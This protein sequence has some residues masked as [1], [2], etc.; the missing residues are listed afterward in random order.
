MRAA[1]GDS[2]DGKTVLENI[3]SQINSFKK[4]PDKK[5][6]FVSE[7]G[8]FREGMPTSFHTEGLVFRILKKPKKEWVFDHSATHRRSK[9]RR[10]HGDIPGQ[11]FIYCKI[12]SK[13]PSTALKRAC[14][15]LIETTS[16]YNY[17][18]NARTVSSET[19]GDPRNHSINTIYAGPIHN[20]F[21]DG[22]VPC[23]EYSWD[24]DYRGSLSVRKFKPKL[25]DWSFI[26]EERLDILR[27][28]RRLKYGGLVRNSIIDLSES[29]AL[30]DNRDILIRLWAILE[31][32]ALQ[33]RADYDILSRRVSR[34]F[35]Q[36]REMR[37][38][39]DL[40]R[41]YRNKAVH[42][43]EEVDGPEWSVW[44]AKYFVEK[45]ILF[46]LSTGFLI[47]DR[48]AVG[49]FLDM[50]DNQSVLNTRLRI[51]KAINRFDGR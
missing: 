21:E 4:M 17:L 18:I 20:I 19:A 23:H 46:H 44:K 3:R 38:I 40:L 7:I 25:E 26:R 1:S 15:H 41:K 34:I 31:R 43:L 37:E 6:I 32:L 27:R 12:T 50:P 33:S 30:T 9:L 39:I 28:I 5:Y 36:R 48:A 22:G 2:L 10:L 11:R 14:R 35:K 51:L 45:M 24:S 8:P 13:S 42:E 16:I 29:L 49:E 47:N